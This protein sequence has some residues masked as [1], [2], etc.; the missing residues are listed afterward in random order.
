MI[1]VLENEVD[2]E[3]RYFVPEIRRHLE[4]AGARV[5]VYTYADS[6]GRPEALADADAVVLSGSTAGV[7]ETAS[8][9]WMDELRALVPELV[10]KRV[11]TLGVC[12]G[13]QLVNDALGGTVEHRGLR[14]GIE[15]VRLDDDP[16]FD[17][18]GERVPMVHGDFVTELGDGME[19]IATADYYEYLGSRH[20]DA[21][22]WTVQYHPEFT[23][24]LLPD[25][26]D[27]FGWPTNDRDREFDDVSV[28]RTFENFVRLAAE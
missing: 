22:L 15:R 7:Y 24:A 26:E 3:S 4:E 9:P 13:H 23:A 14:K 2:P 12:F 1:L 18:V 19:R 17:G 21:P 28:E 16:L 5:R 20:R 10:E 8:Y 6:G 11:P 27:D 25:I